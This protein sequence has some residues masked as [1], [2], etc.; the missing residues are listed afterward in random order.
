MSYMVF[1]EGKHA[2]TREHQLLVEAKEEAV[3]LASQPDNKL[4]KVYVMQIVETNEPV[5]MRV[6]KEK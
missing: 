5:V 6:W 2:P 3:R 1:V 4:R